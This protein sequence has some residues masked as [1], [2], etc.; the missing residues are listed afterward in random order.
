M[1]KASLCEEKYFRFLEIVEINECFLTFVNG[2]RY[3][4]SLS[5]VQFI[6]KIG[7]NL[8]RLLELLLFLQNVFSHV[9]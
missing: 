3:Y 1:N 7:L 6:Q 5:H 2:S 9:F 4:F 8:K